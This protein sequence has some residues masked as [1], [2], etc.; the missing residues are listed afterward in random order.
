MNRIKEVL[1]EKGIKQ[2]WLAERLGKSFNTVNGY[3]QNRAQPSLEILYKIAKIL[4]V[5]A[6]DLL[7][8]VPNS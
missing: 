1:E 3:V 7:Q 8:E 5:D 2:V 6:K 4:K